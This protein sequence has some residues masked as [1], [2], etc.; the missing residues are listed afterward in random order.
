M[1]NSL[2]YFCQFPFYP[3]PIYFLFGRFIDTVSMFLPICPLPY[4]FL[5]LVIV[6]CPSPM[7]FIILILT[8]ILPSIRPLVNASSMFHAIKPF[9]LISLSIFTNISTKPMDFIIF[10]L[11][12]I[13][14][15]SICNKYPLTIL[16]IV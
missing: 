11:A 14:I 13:H 5:I 6:H 1:F 8:I 15:A 10:K 3:Y 16:L 7:A 4:I 9:T 12:F 2:L